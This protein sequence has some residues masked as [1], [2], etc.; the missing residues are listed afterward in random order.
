ME[1]EF[2]TVNSNIE[3]IKEIFENTKTIAIIGL[4][5]NEEKASN[6]VA[7]YLKN[8]GFKIVP[9]Y[10]K[11][12]EILGEKVYRSLKEIPF[13]IDMVDIFRKP[14][15]IGQVVDAAIERGDIDTVWTQLGL[16]NN[17]AAQKAEAAGMKV[18]QNKCTKIE[19]NNI[20]N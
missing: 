11:E 17:E 15:V 19:H 12:D 14:D 5:P 20:F 9:V 13:K 3:E 7:N 10:P 8:A 16:V 2:P 6:R 1:C 18:V 4:S